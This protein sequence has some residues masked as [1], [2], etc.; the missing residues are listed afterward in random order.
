MVISALYTN[1]L[2]IL[3]FLKAVFAELLLTNR[4]ST[5]FASNMFFELWRE[6]EKGIDYL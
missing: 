6:D 4:V 5:P 1:F 2:L 3:T